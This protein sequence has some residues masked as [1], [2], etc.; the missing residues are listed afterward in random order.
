MQ[1]NLEACSKQRARIKACINHG[2]A[3]DPWQDDMDC[4]AYNCNK[5]CWNHASYRKWGCVAEIETSRTIL[6]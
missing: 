1:Y 6:L 3:G 4:N 2:E 5:P